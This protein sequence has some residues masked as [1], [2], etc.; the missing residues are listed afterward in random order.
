VQ[1]VEAPGSSSGRS[2][3]STRRSMTMS[4]RSHRPSAMA[5]ASRCWPQLSPPAACAASRQAAARRRLPAV[6]SKVSASASQSLRRGCFLGRAR[7]PGRA[8]GPAG[9]P[10]R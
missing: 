10:G 1:A 3:S 7:S 8:A 5:G 6:R 9:T 2:W 4:V